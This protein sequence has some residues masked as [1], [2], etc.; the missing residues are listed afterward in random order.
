[1]ILETDFQIVA[2]Y[3]WFKIINGAVKVRKQG[4]VGL[5]DK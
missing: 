5:G 1:M 4:V 2:G 3:G